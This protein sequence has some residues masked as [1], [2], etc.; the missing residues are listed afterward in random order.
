MS[1]DDVK[2]TTPIGLNTSPDADDALSLAQK[3]IRKLDEESRDKLE[4][5]SVADK[6]EGAA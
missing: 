5:I 2:P 3:L 4:N 1:Q 6:R